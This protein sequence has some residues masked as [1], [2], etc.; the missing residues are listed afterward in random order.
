MNLIFDFDGTIV[1]S[2]Q[3]VIEKFNL[4]AEK[5]H[6]RK[7]DISEINSLKNLNSRELINYFQIPMHKVPKLI[8]EARKSLREEMPSLVPFAHLPETLQTLHDAGF[9][10]GIV[11][12]NALENVSQWLQCHGMQHLFQFIQ[13]E[14]SFFGKNH[15]LKKIL[16][17]YNIDNT[18]AFYI[19]DETRDIE[20]AKQCGIYSVA[21]TWGFNSEKILL[22]SQPHYVA[23]KPEDILAIF[24]LR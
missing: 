18:Q 12:S 15:V 9:S 4:F 23:R 1:D 10:L 14:S 5:F 22:Q 20:A 17:M 13:I 7:I 21:V 3:A 6:F 2:F 19:G 8:V 11:T 16:R 24:G